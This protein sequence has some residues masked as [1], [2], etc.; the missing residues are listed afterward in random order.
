[1][2]KIVSLLCLL[3]YLLVG[4]SFHPE[5]PTNTHTT[6]DILESDSPEKKEPVSFFLCVNAYGGADTWADVKADTPFPSLICGVEE[7]EDWYRTRPIYPG[8]NLK[9]SFAQ[10]WFASNHLLV[11]AVRTSSASFSIS[12]KE[13]VWENDELAVILAWDNPGFAVVDAEGALLIYLG[14]DKEQ[15]SNST[16]IVVRIL[17]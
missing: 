13:A 15:V 4:C 3:A 5:Q 14:I 11:V 12:F 10:S 6:E 8:A 16:E 2:K 7:L 1:M 9:I 17:N